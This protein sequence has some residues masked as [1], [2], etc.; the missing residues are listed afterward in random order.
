MVSLQK[1]EEQITNE[2]MGKINLSKDKEELKDHVVNLSKCVIDLSKKNDVDMS[3]LRA[4][5]VV[6]L[7]Y[8]GSMDELYRRGVVQD[9]LKRLVPLGLTFDDNGSLDVYLFQ[10]T[11]R[12]MDDM[13]IQNYSNYVKKVIDKSGYYMG[14]TEYAP[15]LQAIVDER[16]EGDVTES[17]GSIFKKLFTKKNTVNTDNESHTPT[18]VLF[19]TD[20]DNSDKKETRSIL[21][22]YSNQNWFIQFIGLGDNQFR[23]LEELDDLE[24]RKRDNTG[25][26]KINDIEQAEDSKLFNIILSEFSNWLKGNQ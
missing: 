22:K 11:Y 26:T 15:V 5:V 25:F 17:G 9:T 20:G 23:F 6:V 10:D 8:S 14:G 21:K 16:L 3:A 18:F 2:V 19:L 13:N 12:K 4:K 24:G 1:T 7:D